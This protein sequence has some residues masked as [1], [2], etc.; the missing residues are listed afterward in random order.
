MMM[1][2]MMM[3]S[4]RT[5]RKEDGTYGADGCQSLQLLLES[6]KKWWTGSKAFAAAGSVHCDSLRLV[7]LG[8]D[9]KATQCG[10]PTGRQLFSCQH[11]PQSPS[12]LGIDT[13][14]TPQGNSYSKPSY[15]TP[16][17]PP[18]P[19]TSA[20]IGMGVPIHGYPTSSAA[21]GQC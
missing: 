4:I 3:F 17:T 11:L 7:L 9:V 13:L 8:L 14:T 19:S 20:R 12:K 5:Q 16:F 10:I 18:T 21:L 1:I 2:I 15:F 6:L